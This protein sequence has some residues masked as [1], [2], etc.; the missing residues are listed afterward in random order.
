MPRYGFS[1][2]REP[3]GETS[4]P[5]SGRRSTPG[6]GAI[7]PFTSTVSSREAVNIVT[8]QLHQACNISA[9]PPQLWPGKMP[10]LIAVGAG[11]VP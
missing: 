10:P 4:G 1:A 3:L 9:H 7:R 5:L 11:R 6:S 2:W 8:V